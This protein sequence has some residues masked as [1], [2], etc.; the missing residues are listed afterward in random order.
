MFTMT[1]TH[2]R[3]DKTVKFYYDSDPEAKA[4]ADKAF[5]LTSAAPGFISQEVFMADDGLSNLVVVTWTDQASWM[6]YEEANK[7]FLDAYRG[8]RIAYEAVE[9]GGTNTDGVVT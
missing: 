4:L 7:G 6:S 9:G 5:A 3:K 8:S 1:Y 2:T